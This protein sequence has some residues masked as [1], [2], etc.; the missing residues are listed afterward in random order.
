[1]PPD[2]RSASVQDFPPAHLYVHVPFCRSKCAY[3]AFYSEAVP[4]PEGFAD[5]IAAELQLRAPNGLALETLYLG[6]GTPTALGRDGLARL[7][8][9]LNRWRNGASAPQEWTVEANPGTLTGPMAEDLLRAG[10]TR[11][12]LGAQAFD[13]ASLALLGRAHGTAATR[14]AFRAARAAGFRSV[15]LDLIAGIPG[16]AERTWRKTLAEAMALEPEHLSVY[17][18]SLEPGTPLA[19]AVAQDRQT[20]PSEDEQMDAL[21]AAEAFLAAHGYRR[22]E[23]SNYAREGFECRHNLAVWRGADYLGVGPAAASRLGSLR[24]ENAP[25]HARWAAALASGAAPPYQEETLRPEAD[26]EE[27]LLTR[28][29][30]AEGIA[31]DPRY[32]CEARL[33]NALRRL[34]A[35]QVVEEHLPGRWRLTARGREVADAVLRELTAG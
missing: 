26:A 34:G 9:T 23:I 10:A 33:A 35:L 2:R 16:L 13:D 4:P 32:P 11:I 25:D 28:L 14:N 12:S 27:R 1:M 22:Y 31:P 6:G 20:L 21:A 17:L 18:L 24:R 29:R 8:A 7:C 15:G 30:L 5:A 3:C 19:Q